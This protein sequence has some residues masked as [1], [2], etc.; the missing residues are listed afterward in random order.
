MELSADKWI[1]FLSKKSIPSKEEVIILN[2]RF[3]KNLKIK[4]QDW[5]HYFSEY[6]GMEIK[7]GDKIEIIPKNDGGPGADIPDSALDKLKSNSDG[8]FCITRRDGRYFLKA[9]KLIQGKTEVPACLVLDRFSDVM[10]EREYW[11]NTDLDNVSHESI[12]KLIPSMPEFKYNPLP[13]LKKADGRIGFLTNMEFFGGLTKAQ[14]SAVNE[15]KKEICKDQRENGSWDDSAAKTAFNLLRLIEVGDTLRDNPVEKGVEWLLNAKEPLGFPGL[16]MIAEKTADSFNNWKE[17][18]GPKSKKRGSRSSSSRQRGMFVENADIVGMANSFCEVKL[19]WT[20]AL[21]LE[22]MLRCGLKDEERVVKGINTLLSMSHGNWCGCGYFVANI[23]HEPS[24]EPIDFNKLSVSTKGHFFGTLDISDDEI[25]QIVHN[26]GFKS[27]YLDDS[28]SLT[29]KTGHQGAGDCAIVVNKALSYHPDYHGSNL[30]TT[31]AVQCSF[32]QGWLGDWTGNYITFFMDMLSH[33]KCPL[34]EYLVLR[35]IP[36]LVR[37]QNSD[38]FWEEPPLPSK[39]KEPLPVP[40]REE[41]TF[42]IVKTLKTFGFL[43]RLM[44]N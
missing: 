25:I 28:E 27:L 8:F 15:Y 16:F 22:A 4:K 1:D 23:Y 40:S 42:A 2:K 13:A 12:Q 17:K 37:D 11:N 26:Y 9:L 10:V 38:G 6:G 32:R 19:T 7:D 30:E 35:T 36:R 41:T 39:P 24:L 44:P 29:V 34:S 14:E 5:S 33:F 43:D 20:S 21:A 18:Q 3:A 31:G